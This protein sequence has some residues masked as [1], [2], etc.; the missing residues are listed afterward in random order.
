MI[1]AIMQGLFHGSICPVPVF[2][3][4]HPGFGNPLSCPAAGHAGIGLAEV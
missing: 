3:G 1:M 4:D 2:S